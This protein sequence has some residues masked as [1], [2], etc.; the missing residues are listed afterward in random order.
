MEVFVGNLAGNVSLYEL[1][2]LFSEFKRPSIDLVEKQRSDGS[3]LRYAVV[4]IESPRLAKKAIRKFEGFFLHER[5]LVL[6]EFV[7]RSYINERRA[8]D[9]R[10]RAWDGEER[11]RHLKH[12]FL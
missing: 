11:R 6:H 10:T 12:L 1:N 5:S 8:L 3:L 2:R 7:H 4:D 9:W